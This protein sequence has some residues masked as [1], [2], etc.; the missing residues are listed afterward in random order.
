MHIGNFKVEIFKTHFYQFAFSNCT[1][2]RIMKF[3]D[4]RLLVKIGINLEEC[5][6]CKTEKANIKKLKVFS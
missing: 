5:V 3:L 6:H 2:L 1:Y 4:E